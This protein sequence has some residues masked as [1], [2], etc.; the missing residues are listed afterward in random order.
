MST[1]A[2]ASLL[3]VLGHAASG[4]AG[5]AIS[6]VVTYPLDI[7]TGRLKEPRQLD[8]DGADTPATPRESVL[9]AVRTVW[10]NEGGRALDF[11]LFADIAESAADSFLFFLFYILF[12]SRWAKAGTKTGAAKGLSAAGEL[13][14]AAAA[15]AC[16]RLITTPASNVTARR[17]AAGM[18]DRSPAEVLRDMWP[19]GGVRGLWAGYEASLMLTLN[20]SITFFVHRVLEKTRR[21]KGGSRDGILG[22]GLTFLLAAASNVFATAV[23]YPFRTA[24]ARVCM[25][26][27]LPP[28]QQDEKG[29]GVE[30]A[31]CD[32]E[33]AGGKTAA[34]VR[35][36]GHQNVFATIVRTART[37][38]VGALYAGLG[39]ELLRAFLSHGTTM[40]AKDL[41]HR[42]VIQL[43][44]MVVAAL[45][46][47]PR[48]QAALLE[49]SGGQAAPLEK[50]EVQAPVLKSVGSLSA[51]M[52]SRLLQGPASKGSGVGS[53][54]NSN[55]N[56][57]SMQPWRAVPRPVR[58][59]HDDSAER[60]VINML[61]GSH[62]AVNR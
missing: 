41:V 26:S 13:T 27:V 16:A 8:E 15:E 4:A 52:Q 54:S 18:P 46:R 59:V 50:P 51:Q 9:S 35:A 40:L 7:A 39:S 37:E 3:P 62:R 56:S 24:R 32:K 31:V 11:R 25:S 44:L 1:A 22:A 30:E 20:P 36:P 33:E 42:Y 58:R 60:F 23:T 29:G 49:K 14:V 21:Q 61:E 53:G 28:Q 57:N 19:Q 17:Q 12:R 47:V 43:Y 5:T 6:T 34:A 38:G 2:A 45:R 48:G 55:S 10:A